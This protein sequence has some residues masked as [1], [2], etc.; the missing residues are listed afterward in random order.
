MAAPA[1]TGVEARMLDN[2]YHLLR[3]LGENGLTE[4]WEAEDTR[5]DRQV[6]VRLLGEGSR[7]DSQARQMLRDVAHQRTLDQRADSPRVLDGGEDPRFGPFVVA[8]MIDSFEVTR[9]LVSGGSKPPVTV[10]PGVQTP[11]SRAGLLALALL[12]L[13]IVVS[14][15]LLMRLVAS[16]ASQPSASPAIAA[17]E[18]PSRPLSGAASGQPT[19]PATPLPTL[20]AARL[21]PTSA[22]PTV[23]PT[24]PPSA[25]APAAAPVETIRQHYA[26][27]NARNY[28]AGY[29]LMDSRLQSLN[30]PS[31][32]AGWFADK[33]AVQP[34]SVDQV[35][36]TDD[37]AVV[38]SMVSSTDRVNGE[39]VTTRVAEKFVLHKENGAWRI[40]QVTRQ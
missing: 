4:S 28:A 9:P 18:Q 1:D 21:A 3:R 37:Q 13:V 34:I 14:S 40:D 10:A 16:P 33:V 22:Q 36:Q 31:D 29:Q 6:V 38:N 32:Y 19:A 5:L 27:I 17:T 39:D 8:E 24:A 23:V 7:T 11:R 35:S 12:T 20:A 25:A 2:R 30:S 26:L 15:V